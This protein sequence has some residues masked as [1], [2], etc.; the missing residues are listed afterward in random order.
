[1]LAASSTTASAEIACNEN[2]DCWR[3]KERYNYRP[4]FGI[5][6]HPNDWRGMSATVGDIGG[7]NTTTTGAVTG[8]M[9]SGSI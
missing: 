1:V 6:I 5:T 3:I 8:G 9:M 7:A 4:E 2:G